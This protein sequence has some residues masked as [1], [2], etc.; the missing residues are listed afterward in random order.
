MHFEH[1]EK[2]L[3][4]SI[5]VDSLICEGAHFFGNITIEESIQLF[6]FHP[7][8]EFLFQNYKIFCCAL[9]S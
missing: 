7:S 4:D 9:K 5:D 6:Y 2:T 1:T 8:T 3:P